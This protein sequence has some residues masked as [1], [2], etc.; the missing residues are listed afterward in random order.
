MQLSFLG[1][2][3]T[4]DFI[5]ID[6]Q[7][8]VQ[9]ILDHLTSGDVICLYTPVVDQYNS[10]GIWQSSDSSLLKINP[11]LDIAFVGQKEGK[12]NYSKCIPL[13]IF[14]IW[15]TINCLHAR[16]PCWRKFLKGKEFLSACRY[17]TRLV[18]FTSFIAPCYLVSRWSCTRFITSLWIYIYLLSMIICE[19]AA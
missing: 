4:A 11:A 17:F 15:F 12:E 16:R 10:P 7:Q 1:I 2:Q 18:F 5:K 9:P 3:N 8:S 6:V 13:C 19:I 14:F